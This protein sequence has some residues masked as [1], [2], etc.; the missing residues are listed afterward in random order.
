[1][2]LLTPKKFRTSLMVLSAA[3]LLSFSGCAD[4]D[5]P[6][7]VDEIT[8]TPVRWTSLSILEPL[9]HEGDSPEACDETFGDYVNGSVFKALLEE[10]DLDTGLHGLNVI[11][12]VGVPNAGAALDLKMSFPDS[13][14][15]GES[16]P[17]SCKLA[18]GSMTDTI[19]WNVKKATETGPCFKRISTT[20]NGDGWLDNP[21]NTLAAADIPVNGPNT[22]LTATT[23]DVFKIAIKVEEVFEIPLHGAYMSMELDESGAEPAIKRGMLGGF[24]TA[25][26]ADALNFLGIVIFS[27]L[28]NGGEGAC[29][30]TVDLDMGPNGTGETVPG[31]WLY[32]GFDGEYV[33]DAPR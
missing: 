10:P 13:C 16:G 24:I 17:A 3:A 22:C 11:Q 8:I 29:V 19:D 33:V 9:L 1:M 20:A 28:L 4:D 23:D 30:D 27:E 14:T 31:W 12:Q 21:E 15:P 6:E 5:D 7:P 32:V 25:A 18:G 2:T 26:E